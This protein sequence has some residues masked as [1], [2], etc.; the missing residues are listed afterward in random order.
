MYHIPVFFVFVAYSGGQSVAGTIPS[1][2]TSASS[3]QDDPSPTTSVTPITMKA[4]EAAAL[5]S[6]HAAAT[7]AYPPTAYGEYIIQQQQGKTNTPYSAPFQW[8][9]YSR[10]KL[11]TQRF[12]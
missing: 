12:L 5:N 6:Y 1:S 8:S 2:S 11:K 3:T 7:A 4:A 9:G 10:T